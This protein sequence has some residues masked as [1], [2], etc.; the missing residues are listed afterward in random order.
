M[1]P[2]PRKDDIDLAA[3]IEA[4]A[5]KLYRIA[6]ATRGF[7]Y[8]PPRALPMEALKAR[9]KVAIIMHDL[10]ASI[11]ECIGR[12]SVVPAFEDADDPTRNA[13]CLG[14]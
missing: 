8:A 11:S 2:L 1:T 3:E 14:G 9:F 10:Q 7:D 6:A 12:P 5:D 13:L 4:A